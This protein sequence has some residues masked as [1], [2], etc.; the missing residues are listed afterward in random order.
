MQLV[1][2]SNNVKGNRVQGVSPSQ[3]VLRRL[4]S[5]GDGRPQTPGQR[6]EVGRTGT[7]KGLALRLLVGPT[8]REQRCCWAFI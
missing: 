2:T 5:R 6:P 8:L 1:L 3:P 4:L 7:S